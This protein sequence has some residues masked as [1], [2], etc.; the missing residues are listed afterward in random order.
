MDRSHY[1]CRNFGY[2]WLGGSASSDKNQ[3]GRDLLIY[4]RFPGRVELVRVDLF[5][6]HGPG[7][8]GQ[9]GIL[10]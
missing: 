5:H 6:N 2:S 3:E 10:Y 1:R 8:A 9:F 7:A 4:I